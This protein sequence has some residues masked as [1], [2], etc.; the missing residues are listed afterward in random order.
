MKKRKFRLTPEKAELLKQSI[1]EVKSESL[2]EVAKNLRGE[3]VGGTYARVIIGYT[4]TYWAKI[5]N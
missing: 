5:V 4:Q 1:E 2:K 3:I